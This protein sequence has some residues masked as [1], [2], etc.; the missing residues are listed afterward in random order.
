MQSNWKPVLIYGGGKRFADT[1]TAKNSN[2]TAKANHHW[3]QDFAAFEQIVERLT[4]PGQTVVDPFMGA[5][6]TL[7][8]A[9]SIGR[10]V[11]GC[12]VE[13]QHVERAKERFA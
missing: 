7:I 1:F 6:T 10:N 3:G 11:I 5:G 13:K 2:D 9:H 8:A 12:D 4:N